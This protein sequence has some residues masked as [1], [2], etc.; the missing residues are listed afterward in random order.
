M[1]YYLHLLSDRII[2]FNVFT[3][4]TFRSVAAAVTAFVI[5]LMFGSF[6]IRKL[7]SLKIG[8]PIRSKE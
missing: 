5:S 3:Y 7:I 1:M 6:V 8:Q 2:G 4:V